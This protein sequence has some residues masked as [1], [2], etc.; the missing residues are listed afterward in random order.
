MWLNYVFNNSSEIPQR[1]IEFVTLY[2]YPRMALGHFR[3]QV[4]WFE[5]ELE[6]KLDFQWKDNWQEMCIW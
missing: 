6:E 5:A 3:L 2:T 1:L 4:W